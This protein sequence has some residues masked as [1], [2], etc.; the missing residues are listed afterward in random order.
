[1]P[2]LCMFSLQINRMPA[3]KTKY[4]QERQKRINNLLVK[5]IVKVNQYFDESAIFKSHL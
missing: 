2:I 5:F 4:G 3:N 1:M